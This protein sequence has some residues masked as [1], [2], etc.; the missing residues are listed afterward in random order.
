[1]NN[2]TETSKK[3]EI[4]LKDLIAV[5]YTDDSWSDDELG[6]LA[7]DYYKRVVGVVGES[8]SDSP[9][10]YELNA[11]LRRINDRIKTIRAA[12]HGSALPKDASSELS[13]LIASRDHVLSMLKEDDIVEDGLE[14]NE[15]LN[16][17]Q[18]MKR[19]AIMR[20]NKA[21]MLAGRRRAQRR[22][23]S[24]SVLQQ[25][26]VRAAR[27]L[28]ARRLLRKDKGEASY[29]EKVRVEKALATRQ[30]AI[31]RLARKL[32]SRI[33]QKEQQKFQHKH[34]TPPRPVQSVKPVQTPHKSA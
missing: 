17:M 12:H 8:K 10:K 28:L 25:R 20:R 31:K 9:S 26:S 3:K 23:A 32:M 24:T 16:I 11:E 27:A 5:D 34:A 22:R 15:A 29:A 2:D 33:R 19:R 13:K 4:R 21:K 7:Y 1:M 14:I 6:Q 30:G 18:R